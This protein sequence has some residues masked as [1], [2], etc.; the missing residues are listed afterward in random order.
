MLRSSAF[1]IADK[2][3]KL[4]QRIGIAPADVAVSRDEILKALSDRDPAPALETGAADGHS[5]NGRA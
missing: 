2:L 3:S 1:G 5:A 4:R